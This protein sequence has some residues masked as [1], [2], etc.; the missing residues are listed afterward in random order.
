MMHKYNEVCTRKSPVAAVLYKRGMVI[1]LWCRRDAN[2]SKGIP[3]IRLI[4]PSTLPILLKCFERIDKRM[5]MPWISARRQI[6]L[7]AP[8]ERVRVLFK[9]QRSKVVISLKL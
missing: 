6:S 7:G 5:C 1:A 8:S 4:T 9:R 3:Q 2:Q